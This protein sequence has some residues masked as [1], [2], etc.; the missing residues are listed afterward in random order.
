MS[1]HYNDVTLSLGKA[2]LASAWRQAWSRHGKALSRE[3]THFG[4]ALAL[5]TSDGLDPKRESTS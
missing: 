5:E 1:R 3:F 2:A 4:C